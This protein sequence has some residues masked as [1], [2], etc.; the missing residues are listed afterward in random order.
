MLALSRRKW[1]TNGYPGCGEDK[2]TQ[3]VDW[4]QPW[5]EGLVGTGERKNEC[6]PEM[7]TRSPESRLHL[8]LFQKKHG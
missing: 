4:E 1:E 3:R 5:K 8:E 7:C 6:E 2:G